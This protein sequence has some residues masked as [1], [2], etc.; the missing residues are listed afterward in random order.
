MGTILWALNLGW[1]LPGLSTPP[2]PRDP[3]GSLNPWQSP[4]WQLADPPDSPAR[5][6]SEWSPPSATCPAGPV[7]PRQP[8]AKDP[9]PPFCSPR[10][11]TGK[12]RVRTKLWGMERPPPEHT[13]IWK[14][15][16][17][18]N[19]QFQPGTCLSPLSLGLLAQNMRWQ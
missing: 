15:S 10:P 6:G 18:L 4:S 3:L 8:Q 1:P 7:Q 19:P 11:Q 5:T 14:Q 9:L 13:W 12:A 2:H 17:E 16:P